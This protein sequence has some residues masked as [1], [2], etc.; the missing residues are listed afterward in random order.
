MSNNSAPSTSVNVASH[1]KTAGRGNPNPQS[2]LP[3]Q[4]IV[5]LISFNLRV[6]AIQK[7]GAR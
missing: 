6:P 5:L 1:A 2:A 3:N 4:A 7:I